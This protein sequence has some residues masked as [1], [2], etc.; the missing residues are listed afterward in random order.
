MSSKSTL[1]IVFNIMLIL[2]FNSCTNK[3]TA[4]LSKGATNLPY[5]TRPTGIIK[6][7]YG[8]ITFELFPEKAPNTINRLTQLINS[9]FYDG[10]KFHRVIPNYIIQTG[11]PTNTGLGGSGIK[12]KN[13]SNNIPHTK[14]TMAMSKRPSDSIADSQ[15]FISLKK[16]ENLDG[17]YTVFGRVVSGSDILFKIKKG[18]RIISMTLKTKKH[19]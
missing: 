9:G 14:G 2:L 6:T 15:F 8:N 7:I 19:L 18:D 16:L 13:E 11:D 5:Y 1:I 10:I 3:K 4:E 17:K 12:I